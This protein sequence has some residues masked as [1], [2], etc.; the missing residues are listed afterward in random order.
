MRVTGL[1]TPI[2]RI[3]RQVKDP[4]FRLAWRNGWKLTEKGQ[5]K[6]KILVYLA[7]CEKVA[8]NCCPSCR[9][10]KYSLLRPSEPCR[11][12][13]GTGKW[14]IDDYVKAKAI[15]ISK[16]AYSKTWRERFDDILM[17][18]ETREYSAK[19]AIYQL[20]DRS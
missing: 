13:R 1:K 16:Q 5:K 7:I 18:L 15:G 3:Y 4:A 11:T 6:F 17:L 10:T 12:C 9:G 14:K 8:T 19:R 2:P 20:L